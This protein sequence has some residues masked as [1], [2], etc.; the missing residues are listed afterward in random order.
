VLRAVAFDY[1]DTLAEFRWDEALWRRGVAALLAAAGADPALAEAAGAELR[2]R[3][4][5]PRDDLRELDYAAAVGEVLAGL[6]ADASAAAVRRGIEAEYHAWAPARRVHPD[7]P[8]LLDGVR[9][10]GLAIAVVA[11]TFDPPGL[12]RAD[13]D[14]QGIAGRVDAIVLSC[15]LGVRT[16][17]PAVYAAVAAAL[18]VPAQEVM[19]VGDTVANDVDGPAAA[20]MRGCLAAWHRR[21]PAAAGRCVPICTEPR[22]LLVILEALVRSGSAGKI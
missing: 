8:A 6:G 19:V 7:A 15:E 13:L 10:L 18:G 1:R 14:R 9:A 16:P 5:R 4:E 11:N 20:G 22:Q 3:F 17:H 2:R 12:F 21:D